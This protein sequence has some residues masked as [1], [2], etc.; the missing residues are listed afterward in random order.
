MPY[1]IESA[2]VLREIY[3][4]RV[5]A[6]FSSMERGGGGERWGGRKKKKKENERGEGVK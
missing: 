3:E 1:T 5:C 2:L 6:E 4:N